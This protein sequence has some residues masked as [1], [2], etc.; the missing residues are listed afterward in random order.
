MRWREF[1]GLSRVRFSVRS[2]GVALLFAPLVMV[3]FGACQNGLLYFPANADLTE[4]IET[5]RHGGLVPWENSDAGEVIG[6]K[7]S[8]AKD[9]EVAFLAFHGNAGAAFHRSY[10]LNGWTEFSDLNGPGYVLEYPGY[11]A[12]AGQPGEKHFRVAASEAL[13]MVR[14][15]WSG[16]LWLVGESIGSGTASWLA[17]K[18]PEEVDGVILITPFDRLREVARTH[19]PGWLVRLVIRDEYDNVGNLT[20]FSGPVV[21]LVA[22]RDTVILPQLAESLYEQLEGPKLRI[23]EPQ[24]GHNSFPHQPDAEWRKQVAEFIREHRPANPEK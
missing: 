7:R 15:E 5:A 19:A 11:G 24:A 8:G 21:L 10:L 20:K 1:Y 12:R 17:G 13:S 22:G 6:W 16:P 2:L 4:A 3:M 14:K 18:F 23:V 9:A